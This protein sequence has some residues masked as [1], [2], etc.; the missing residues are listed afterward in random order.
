M[1]V[2]III[3]Y[4]IPMILAGLIHW[5]DKETKT[6]GDFLDAWWVILIPILNIFALVVT[7]LDFFID[8]IKKY[9]MGKK[10][11]DSWNRFINIKIK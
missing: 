7:S 1:I 5:F 2:V 6:M 3:F 8:R 9:G 11:N 4:I 10:M